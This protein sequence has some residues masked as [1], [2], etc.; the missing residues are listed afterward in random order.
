[1]LT[2]TGWLALATAVL[3]IGLGGCPAEAGGIVISTPAGLSPGDSFRIVFVTDALN[4]GT[5]SSIGD[6]N[7]FVSTDAT[8]EA[9]GGLVTYNGVA[10]TWSAIVSTTSTDAIPNVGV[11]GAPVYL[12]G[13]T[14]VTSSDSSSG[15]WSGSLSNPINQDLKGT[16]LNDTGVWTGTLTSGTGAPAHQLG[17][18][19]VEIGSTGSENSSWVAA[20]PFPTGLEDLAIYGISQVLIVPI[21]VP[22]PS[23]LVMAGTVI[24]AGCAF[25]WSRRRRTERR[26]RNG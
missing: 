18:S 3:C 22:E 16:V 14:L 8:S 11:S 4:A 10:L 5:S 7:S 19:S 17:N 13:G 24:G 25:G 12:A 21:S 15:L 6:Y 9:A 20:F 2:R 23:T 1:M 26:Q